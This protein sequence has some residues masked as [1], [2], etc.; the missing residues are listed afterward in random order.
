MEGLQGILDSQQEELQGIQSWVVA[1]HS[2]VH[3]SLLCTLLFTRAITN[4]DLAVQ[5]GRT[6]CAVA[7]ASPRQVCAVVLFSFPLHPPGKPVP[8]HSVINL[9]HQ[10]QEEGNHMPS[11]RLSCGTR[12]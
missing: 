2:M 5:G 11:H 10:P 8:F 4:N 1:G 3:K 12:I 6:A 9:L 7:R